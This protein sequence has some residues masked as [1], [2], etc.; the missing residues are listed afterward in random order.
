MPGSTRPIQVIGIAGSLRAQS[1]NRALLRAA[2]ELAPAEITLTTQDLTAIPLYN[3]DVEA[4]GDPQ[5]VLA[6]KSAVQRADA[7]LLAVAEYNYGM[8]G[9]LKNTIDWLSRPPDHSVLQDKPV[10]LMGASPG[11]TGTARAQLQLRQAFVFTKT[12][13]MLHPEILVAHADEK[14][15]ARGRLTDE[16]TRTRLRE[17]L[18]ALVT[19][20]RRFTAS[21]EA[22]LLGSR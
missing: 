18:E 7:L 19:W 5:P 17:L 4:Q 6:L 16:A 12:N 10:A 21:P 11:M 3:A 9:V 14:F 13:A 22:M 1:Y 20:T 15:D 2:Q 8:S